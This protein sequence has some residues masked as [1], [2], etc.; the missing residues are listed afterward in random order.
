[1]KLTP[2]GIHAARIG[3]ILEAAP[4]ARAISLKKYN[5][6]AIKRPMANTFKNPLRLARLMVQVAA[7]I[8][9]TASQKQRAISVCHCN[10]YLTEDSPEFSNKVINEGSF[11]KETTS[12]L[13]VEF[14]REVIVK[15]V[16]MDRDSKCIGAK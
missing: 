8:T 7:K 1:M 9:I 15:L 16:G 6:K 11:Q 12:G 3:G 14:L 4:K 13:R 5:V 10:T 2:M